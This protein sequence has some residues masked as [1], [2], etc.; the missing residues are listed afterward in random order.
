[1]DNQQTNTRKQWTK[2]EMT[3][4]VRNNAEEAVL[5]A[6]KTGSSGSSAGNT[7]TAC[8]INV[9][10]TICDTCYSQASS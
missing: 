7:D 6:C 4:L 1:M 2:P 8:L 3:V 9:V 10:S 5:T